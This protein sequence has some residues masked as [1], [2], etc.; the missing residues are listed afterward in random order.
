MKRTEPGVEYQWAIYKNYTSFWKQY[1]FL[2]A[3]YWKYYCKL[4][5]KYNLGNEY[6]DFND[7]YYDSWL[8]IKNAVDA[9]KPENIPDKNKWWG[10]MQL[11]FY[12][13]NWVNRDLI[14]KRLQEQSIV[15]VLTERN[16]LNEDTETDIPE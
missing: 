14:I 12:L 6:C 5:E 16:I 9:V 2:I 13:R 10:Y 3:N 7:F 1:R 8:V 15:N 4:L 11:S